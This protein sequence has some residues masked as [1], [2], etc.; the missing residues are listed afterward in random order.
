MRRILVI[1]I[2]VTV[3]VFCGG[4]RVIQYVPVEAKTDSI[5]I[6]KVVERI[7]TV[8]IEIPPEVQVM[9]AP[10][11]SSHLETGIA[12]SEARI[13]S[14]GLLHHRL[15]NKKGALEKQVIYKDKIIEKTVEKEVPV[16][17]EVTKEVKVVPGYYKTINIVFWSLIA[18]IVIFFVIFKM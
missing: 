15:W 8:R 11:D 4:C 1:L 17:K 6:E 5:Y 7:D 3:A 16:I 13:D 2:A 9:I 14:T 18:G 10:V 12:V